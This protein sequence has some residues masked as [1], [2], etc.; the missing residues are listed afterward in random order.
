M[1]IKQHLF[2]RSR[3]LKDQV[4]R[5]A[6]LGLA[7]S[8]ISILVAS[9][10]VSYKLTGFIDVPGIILAQKSNPA[11]WALDLTPFMFAYWGQSFCYELAST[12]ETMVEDKTRELVNKSSD[13]ELKLHYE[14][15]HDHLTNLPNQRLLMQRINQ[16]MKQIGEGDELALIILHIDSFKDINYK[17]GSFNA[18]SLLVQFAEKLKTILLEPYLLQA[19]MGMNMVARMQGAEFAML[20]P[21]LKKDHHL[22]DILNKLL[23]STAS[24]YMIDGNSVNVTTSL[25]IAL[26]PEHGR[27]ENSL[28]QL[29]SS[30]L[31]YAEK[32]GLSHAIY[33]AA[34]GKNLKDKD[35]KV[36]ELNQ[37]LDDKEIEFLYQPFVEL[38]TEKILGAETLIHFDNAEYGVLNMDQL[39]PLVEGT[40]LVRKLM[41]RM[42]E[43]AVQ[44][45][46]LWHQAGHKIYVTVNLTD[47]TDPDLPLYVEGLLKDN[48]I[49]PNYLKLALTEKACLTEQA[50]SITILKQL[51]DLGIKIMISDFCSGYSSF[52]YLT[53]FPISEIKIDE[54]FVQNMMT[55]GKK[56]NIVSAA[57]K[58][59]DVMKLSVFAG[60]V[61]DQKTM[62]KVK[63][64]GCLY[65][66]GPYFSKAVSAD[67]ISALL[68]K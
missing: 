62:K 45:L 36:K 24:N 55:D 46:V 18:N 9:I 12:A 21:R 60:G 64:L 32:A 37:A 68:N 1:A 50:R 34:M 54:S 57:I 22:E 51:T 42:L 11:L 29:A 13:L 61:V 8:L 56:L 63:Q 43:N 23:A 33:N 30:S 35:V 6:I 31:F 26:Y 67:G 59:A 2:I 52:I 3:V 49:S 53:N 44:Q 58:I 47:A 27:D 66:Q 7:I 20:I 19:Y 4:N 28:I 5:Y 16:G 48:N 39:L 15:N 14:T 40:M 17:Y 10:L 65:A 38:K 25:G 41:A